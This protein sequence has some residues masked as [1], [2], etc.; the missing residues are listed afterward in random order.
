MRTNKEGTRQCTREIY[1]ERHR[2][3]RE[4]VRDGSYRLG[5]GAR[6]GVVTQKNMAGAELLRID[7]MKKTVFGK[8]VDAKKECK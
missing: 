6:N 2:A 7:V 3:P 4:E 8:F 5:R 1:K